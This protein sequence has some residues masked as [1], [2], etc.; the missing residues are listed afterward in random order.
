MSESVLLAST[1]PKFLDSAANKLSAF[2]LNVDKFADSFT[3]NI[4]RMVDGQGSR[5]A[6]AGEG[7]TASTSGGSQ[8]LF[9]GPFQLGGGGGGSSSRQLLR[10]GGGGDLSDKTKAF[11]GKMGKFTKNFLGGGDK[12]GSPGRRNPSR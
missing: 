10:T 5:P 12:E 4:N 9:R 11:A 8:P 3:N 7:S 2:N 1:A 6:G